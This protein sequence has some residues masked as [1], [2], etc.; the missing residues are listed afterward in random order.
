MLAHRSA[1][2]CPNQPTSKRRSINNINTGA[3]PVKPTLENSILRC[4]TLFAFLLLAGFC[5]PNLV[6]AFQDVNVSVNGFTIAKPD[7]NND[8]G[9]NTVMG[10]AAGTTVYVV[11]KLPEKRIIKVADFSAGGPTLKDSA[12]NSMSADSSSFMSNI[13]DDGKSVVLPISSQDLPTK[14][15]TSIEVGGNVKLICGAEP[16]T[17]EVD[18]KLAEGEKLTLA[19]IEFT[20][21]AIGRSFMKRNAEMIELQCR[22][23]PASI[24]SISAVLGNGKEVEISSS[25]TSELNSGKD[26][27]FGCTYHIPGKAADIGKLKVAFFES[28]E[29]VEVP[30][31]LKFGLGF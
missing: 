27:R 15:S 4:K 24:S 31:K 30:L 5:F 12:G 1:R 25:G 14:G 21:Q 13:S 3:D 16:K 18:V 19:G 11:V 17:E 8:Y 10:T 29:E 9:S 2:F 26:I 22:K 20:V 23:S 28:S 6:S 7:A